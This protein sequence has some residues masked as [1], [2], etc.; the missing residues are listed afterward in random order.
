MTTAYSGIARDLF[1]KTAVRV[2]VRI[3]VRGEL[4]SYTY[5]RVTAASTSNGNLQ[6]ETPE[7]ILKFAMSKRE[8]T[9]FAAQGVDVDAPRAKRQKTGAAT[10]QTAAHATG[11]GDVAATNGSGSV[12]GESGK[13]GEDPEQVKERGLKLLQ[14]IKDAKDKECVITLWLFQL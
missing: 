2:N 3:A 5:S 11:T 1:P 10:A 12:V 8:A 7:W 13:P 6:L 4:G 14:T 9:L